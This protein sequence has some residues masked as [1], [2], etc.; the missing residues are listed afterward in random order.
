MKLKKNDKNKRTKK[1]GKCKK[2]NKNHLFLFIIWTMKEVSRHPSL[3]DELN[4]KH[5]FYSKT[6]EQ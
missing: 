1:E 5:D 3:L 4:N 2:I 6:K